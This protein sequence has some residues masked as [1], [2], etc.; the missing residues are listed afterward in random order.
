MKM[1]KVK[2]A[3][4][5]LD[6]RGSFLGMEKGC[7]VVKNKHGDVERYPLFEKEIGEVVLKSGNAVST[8]ALS[9]LGFWDIDVLIQT[10]RGRPVAMLRSLDD[11]SHVKTRLCQYEAVNSDKGVY[12]A[13]QFVLGK[14]DGQNTILRKYDLKSQNP[15]Y[16]EKI[17][18]LQSSKLNPNLRRRLM[19]YESNFT[20]NY[21]NQIF[22]LFPEAIRPEGRRTFKAYDGT[23]NLFNLAYEML[24]WKVHRALIN[25]KLEPYLGF[26]HSTQYSK[27]SLVCDFQELYRHFMDDFL[28]KYSQKLIPKD[29][30]VKTEVRTRN[31]KGKR[32]YL[33]DLQTRGLT[34]Q[35]DKFFESHVEIPRIK[36]G[37]KQTIETL[38]TEEAL[39]LAK[40]L[41]NELKEWN[42][43]I[44]IINKR[45]LM[46]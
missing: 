41:R 31:K 38:I 44:S 45:A 39:L 3:K 46:K 25:A 30:I 4:L 37:K 9:A 35:L 20:K 18:K 28:I 34:R 36:V 26:L 21:F 16:K 29:F 8:G 6:G 5:V 11:D 14:F 10:Q 15:T 19:A 1:G 27:P 17:E 40:F 23:N 12:L 42:P 43:R 24:S 2:T 13:K 7:F 33:N 32:V 22:S